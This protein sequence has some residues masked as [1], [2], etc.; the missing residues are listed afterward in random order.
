M[1]EVFDT[2]ADLRQE[3]HSWLESLPEDFKVAVDCTSVNELTL[4]TTTPLQLVLYLRYGYHAAIIAVHSIV[5]HPWNS[6]PFE[7][8]ANEKEQF[9]FNIASGMDVVRHSS[10][11]IILSLQK[12]TLNVTTP[13]W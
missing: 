8:K 3:L 12:I 5:L 9:R 4:T 13:K 10:R 7:V 2:I 6:I 1:R 11:K